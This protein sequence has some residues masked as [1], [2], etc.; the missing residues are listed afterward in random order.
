K[1]I[2]FDDLYID[3][4][5][6]KSFIQKVIEKIIYK[7][8][9]VEL[10]FRKESQAYEAFVLEGYYNDSQNEIIMEETPDCLVLKQAFHIEN[11]ILT[12]R[13][14][15]MEKSIFTKSEMNESLVRAISIGWL[16]RQESEKGVSMEKISSLFKVTG[17]T[18]YKYVNLGYLSPR[19]INDILGNKIP[20]K[21]SVNRLIELASKFM[22]FKDQEEA[23]YAFN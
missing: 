12:N 13:Y 20:E 21:I 23:F 5:K 19:I 17:R 22:T 9:F 8:D 6:L 14:L 16:Y 11:K 10:Y 4:S 15:S 3:Q 18:V 2:D 1:R 7:E